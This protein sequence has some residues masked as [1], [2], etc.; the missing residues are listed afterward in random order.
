MH[1]IDKIQKI[2]DNSGASRNL[3][4]EAMAAAMD[5]VADSFTD[6]SPVPAL[7]CELKNK[8]VWKHLHHFVNQSEL[9]TV[10]II[11]MTAD[12]QVVALH[13]F[14]D[15]PVGNHKAENLFREIM[16]ANKYMSPDEIEMCLEDGFYGSDEGY[17]FT[18]AHS[19]QEK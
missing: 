15:T 14:N 17:F 5:L 3:I 6:G 16:R 4:V 12:L 18:I 7:I 10:N 11:E 19:T 2:I 8:H 9:K 1:P 13:S